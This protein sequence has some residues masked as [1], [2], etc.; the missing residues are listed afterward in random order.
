M[1]TKKGS[2]ILADVRRLLFS[3]VHLTNALYIALSSMEGNLYRNDEVDRW[4]SKLEG[5]RIVI[6]EQLECNIID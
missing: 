1:E 5:N 6:S 3:S 2:F 4:L